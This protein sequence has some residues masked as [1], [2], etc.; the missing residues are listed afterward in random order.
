M[1]QGS[2]RVVPVEEAV[3]DKPASSG[4]RVV[5][6]ETDK[7][8]T[9][10]FSVK[11]LNSS[12]QFD[13]L[14]F[15]PGDTDQAYEQWQ[16]WLETQEKQSFGMDDAIQIGKTMFKELYDGG[17]AF[18]ANL[19]EG[20]FQKIVNSLGE[21]VLRG[22]AD[23]GILSQKGVDRLTRDEAMTRERFRGW[24]EIRKLEAM[25]EKARLGEEDI[26]DHLA[27]S[28]DPDA[29]F[30]YNQTG[31]VDVDPALA[32]GASYGLDIGTVVGGATSGLIR[33]GVG[34]QL[35]RLEG[36]ALRGAGKMAG[37]AMIAAD[38]VVGGVAEK[39]S[40]KFPNAPLR[41]KQAKNL[42]TTLGVI[43]SGPEA[44]VQ[45]A[46]LEAAERIGPAGSALTKSI[47]E[48]PEFP[49][50]MG[51]LERT[52]KN[53]ALPE[54]VRKVAGRA[55]RMGGDAALGLV[56]DVG[57]SAAYGSVAG[58]ALGGFAEGT[59]GAKAGAFAAGLTGG[60]GGLGGR[61]IDTITGQRDAAKME[62]S[63]ND[64]VS[65][66][67]GDK[68][69]LAMLVDMSNLEV[70]D[71]AS[72]NVRASSR[73]ALENLA[74][75]SEMLRGRVDVKVLS[76]EEFAKIT[77]G[78]GVDGFY[79]AQSKEIVVN[80]DGNKISDTLLHEVGEAMWDSGLVSTKSVR[81][82]VARE[83]NLDDLKRSYAEQMLRGENVGRPTEEQISDRV[84]DLDRSYAQ[85]GEEDWVV[86]EMFSENFMSVSTDQG[87]HNYV[88]NNSKL[89]KLKTAV[90][91]AAGGFSQT[92]M[93][94]LG[95]VMTEAKA[96]VFSVIDKAKR[97]MGLD[98]LG[99]KKNVKEPGDTKKPGEP[100]NIFNED[101]DPNSELSK[102]Y[103]EYAKAL[104]R[105]YK[106]YEQGKEKTTKLLK[107]SSDDG[108]NWDGVGKEYFDDV[109]DT[110]QSQSKG[111][112]PQ[113]S[114][115]SAKGGGKKGTRKK[116]KNK[117]ELK[118]R[119]RQRRKE[120]K[121]S[122]EPELTESSVPEVTLKP[123][124]DDAG[125]VKKG[126][127]EYR[128][129][130]LQSKYSDA[131]M[132]E[133]FRGTIDEVNQ[134]IANGRPIRSYYFGIGTRSLGDDTWL[135]SLTR[136][137][138]DI[139][140]TE[141]DYIPHE[142]FITNNGNVNVRV[143][144]LNYVRGRVNAWRDSKK[145]EPWNNDVDAFLEDAKKYLDNH[146]NNISGE[147]GLTTK[148]HNIINALFQ[149]N[150]KTI[151]PL[152]TAWDKNSGNRIYKNLRIER[153]A[154]LRDTSANGTPFG[155]GPFDHLKAKQMFSPTRASS[156]EIDVAHAKAVNS[157]D[158][159]SAQRMVQEAASK[160]GY[161]FGPLYHGTWQKDQVF[162]GRKFIEREPFNSFKI[163]KRGS[164]NTPIN[165]WGVFLTPNKQGAEVYADFAGRNKAGG[166]RRIVN[167]MV[168]MENPY[169]AEFK[170]VGRQFLDYGSMDNQVYKTKTQASEAAREFKQDLVDKGH[171]GIILTDNDGKPYE[172]IVFDPTQIKSA[173]PATYDK[174]G[175]LI[176]LSERFKETTADIRFSPARQLDN[177]GMFSKAQEAIEGM[178]QKKGTSQQ[179]LKAM[180]KAGV[181]KEELEDIG[182]DVFLKDN[183]TTTKE[184]VLNFIRANQIEMV[185]V[186]EVEFQ[187]SSRDGYVIRDTEGGNLFDDTVY[188]T[189][190]EAINARYDQ[191][192]ATIRDFDD[193]QILSADDLP[194]E[195]VERYGVEKG[196]F[197]ITKADEPDELISPYA[198]MVFETEKLAQEALF[199]KVAN[200]FERR[201]EI[202]E[203]DDPQQSATKFSQ[204]TEPGAEPG[205]Y[206]ER[207]LTLQPG[208]EQLQARYDQLTEIFNRRNPTLEE[209]AEYTELER[210]L[211]SEEPNS[212]FGPYS[213]SHFDEANIVAHVRH[214]D[215]I[216][217]DGEKIL[218]LEEIQSDWHQEG[219]SMGY[220]PKDRESLLREAELLYA[221]DPRQAYEKWADNFSK[222][223]AF[224][225][226][227]RNTQ[228]KNKTEEDYV[229]RVSPEFE[230]T[231]QRMLQEGKQ[232]SQK[233]NRLNEL[234]EALSEMG[235]TPNAPFKKSWPEFS[236]KRML[237]LAADEG[238]D[239]IAWTT[240]ETQNARYDL[241]DKI[242]GL[243]VNELEG[244]QYELM[245]RVPEE[246]I[247]R[248]IDSSMT[249]EK[250]QDHIGK[251][252]TKR[253][254]DNMEGPEGV[255]SATLEGDDLR[256][257]GKGMRGFYDEMLPR[258]KLWK[259]TKDS[260]GKPLQVQQ[261]TLRDGLQANYV[262][263]NEDVNSKVS[264]QGLPRY[265]VKRGDLWKSPKSQEYTSAETSIN[266]DK[267]PATF[268][269]VKWERGTVNA[270]I[271]GGRFDN[272][273]DFLARR[274]VKNYIFDPFNRSR[275]HNDRVA[276]T[277]ANGG[278]DTATVNNVLNVIKEPGN[279][280]KVIAQAADAIK[281]DGEA[282]FLIYEGNRSGKGGPTKAGYQNNLGAKSYI[283]EISRYFG[284]VTQ[285]GNLLVATKPKKA[286]ADN[287]PGFNV[288]SEPDMPFADLILSGR[289]T[290]ETRAKPTL[291]SLVGRRVKLIETTGK[292]SGK[293]K[294]EVTVGEPKF[295][296][297][298]AEFDADFD[299]HFVQDS[300]EFAFSEAGKWGYPMEDPVIYQEPYET[301][302][303]LDKLK[304]RVITRSVPGRRFSPSRTDDQGR[305]LGSQKAND[306]RAVELDITSYDKDGKPVFQT[307]DYG[308]LD[309]PF[310]QQWEGGPRGAV[311]DY[312]LDNVHYDVTQKAKAQIK[313]LIDNGAIE[314][315]SNLFVEEYNR[316]IQYPGVTDGMGWYSRMREAIKQVFGK[317]AEMFTHL[318][319]ATSAK[320]PVENNFIYAAELMK[321]YQKG[322][323]NRQIKSYNEMYRLNKD[324]KLYE[325][326]VRR[327]IIA[328]SEAAKMT[329]AAMIK[330]WIEHYNL[331]PVRA[332]GKQYGQ[333][334]LPALKA[335][336]EK[337]LVDKV[338]P[339]TPQ[340]A[341]NL[342][343]SSL[344]ATIDVW[345]ARLM[346]RLTHEPFSEKWRIQP[347]SEGAV[348]NQDFAV[349]QVV[350][351]EA[352]RKLGMNP[353]DLQA[354]V[355]F[356]EKHVWDENGWT[357]NIG[358]FKSSFDEAFDVYFPAGRPARQLSHAEN[359]ISFL[360]KERLIKKHLAQGETDKLK[361]DIRE[362]DKARKL[363]GVQAYIKQTGRRDV[364]KSIPP[365][366]AAD[367]GLGNRRSNRG[368]VPNDRGGAT[369][370]FSPARQLNNR[371][372][373]IY[374]DG[375]GFR[376]VQ[377]SSRAGVRVY[378]DK[379]RRVG[380]VFS[381]VEKAQ[382]H[383]DKL[384]NN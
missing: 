265:S 204:Y 370:K 40:D 60:L 47:D 133:N 233:I 323:F 210:K 256:L 292:G 141:V 282:Y 139:P 200:D 24:R 283:K 312:D 213:S 239:A 203:S 61:A 223:E 313:Q 71:K 285:R 225:E 30:G 246:D 37:K 377:T 255:R 350:F 12:Q 357:G 84:R 331:T 384:R 77:K 226:G 178:Q 11:S 348:N 191:M 275:E 75:A 337:W 13:D 62:G 222:F 262:A 97:G 94:G 160:A 4:F 147:E 68:K 5:P 70:V 339:K 376:A 1:P 379:G 373:A 59:E 190:D 220:A 38:Q 272:A 126:L 119:A 166:E 365:D 335:M 22:T 168:K 355:W 161:N 92:P 261:K 26:I 209:S 274:G 156:P 315:L 232:L 45:R 284:D 33:K 31:D 332:N 252:M 46:A 56:K 193:Y 241:G 319:G 195:T 263:L 206:T 32:E 74:T 16:E 19:A 291:N 257:G 356:G 95:M 236:M 270:D 114:D 324:K 170:T 180:D 116:A 253:A 305:P 251:E 127:N 249:K 352:A 371:G 347:K 151:N 101:I 205:T 298:K 197:V 29:F 336:A 333:N 146:R 82:Q 198:Q 202:L 269:R 3:P 219:R 240:G 360:Q 330:R 374:L 196:S 341:M 35:A 238:Y 245:A 99:H 194:A 361:G 302:T 120:V 234:D 138:G 320:T 27:F 297:T 107:D 177:L 278:A 353:D 76:G 175:N 10:S 149:A 289:K 229:A 235:R 112:G 163:Q 378:S 309:S 214:N 343:G 250:L 303:V 325:T 143:I 184:D 271:G 102:S 189:Y 268:G 266:R 228:P 244:G 318:L 327:K 276:N 258:L 100:K 6:T 277:I 87:L 118:K 372:G 207:L 23:L 349:S 128:G 260:K 98:G 247:F 86:R 366:V 115:S 345:A 135:N 129:K 49:T 304:G 316:L 137:S 44:L 273:T 81:N 188:P 328:R 121:Q 301:N 216:G 208:G 169:T 51:P 15:V 279:R 354:I 28:E 64:F 124:H 281:L 311:Q 88:R 117:R 217:P 326:M 351:R 310:F 307:V 122:L 2:F 17:K 140:A 181:K 322:D 78:R 294:G 340:F 242:T 364:V 130:F 295:Y 43:K 69:A 131:P 183:P 89:G 123:K 93:T 342:G 290:I 201:F 382:D 108:V 157:G 55:S 267:T 67:Q 346:R 187:S 34:K 96:T 145:L 182:L 103:L 85:D 58:A 158:T 21:G 63:I 91:K 314:E 144:D 41:Y 18:A 215:R 179:F 264:G 106:A 132:M 7:T 155:M 317:G 288:K 368:S 185:E 308:I 192:E 164:T 381:S 57:R 172:V 300:S 334:S 286:D 259:Q 109:P 299:K 369:A 20:E 36:K 79:D 42:A 173:D 230:A 25:R 153:I 380:P 321:R 134:A 162:K 329:P 39:I 221:E 358:A 73:K 367:A 50:N 248:V 186:T 159:E 176:P 150:N 227:L 105:Q 83:Y 338:T 306:P 154:S 293:V 148:Q 125:N 383:L 72:G 66:H 359:I 296:K 174:N 90:Q 199:E 9:Q 224:L 48:L 14:T 54:G 344:E 104:N 65:R 165:Q 142:W 218:F 212:R 167:A 113:G 237:K 231:Y 110:P 136:T 80:A 52:S 8:A 211:F 53:M 171:D 111:K 362:Y 375:Y 280:H 243:I 152:Y 363:T 254:L 287:L